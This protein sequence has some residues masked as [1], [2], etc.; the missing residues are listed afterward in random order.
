MARI[1]HDVS[2]NCV[3]RGTSGT[4]GTNTGTEATEKS[5]V[6]GIWF[7]WLSV[8][9]VKLTMTQHAAHDPRL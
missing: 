9:T 3:P 7:F 2:V 1:C 4:R 8:Y 5:R 6:L